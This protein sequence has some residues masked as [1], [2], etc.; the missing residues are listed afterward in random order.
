MTHRLTED[1][2]TTPIPKV[3]CKIEM[4]NL[5]FNINDGSQLTESSWAT[6]D[7][8]GEFSIELL[9]TS[10]VNPAGSHYVLSTPYRPHSDELLFTVPDAGPAKITDFLAED[11]DAP[12][13]VKV[14]LSTD[15]VE[16]LLSSLGLT[17]HRLE[18]HQ[19][20]PASQWTITHT[21]GVKPNVML[22]LPD[23]EIFDADIVLP[24][25]A[26]VIVV[27]ANP[28]TGTAVLT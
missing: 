12:S 3:E 15:E 11:L 7:D 9:P 28:Q 4:P 21:F 22:L 5:A 26:T 27:H 20:T 14:G 6:T 17:S 13:P 18:F 25:N 16:L 1:D 23:G 24:D 10:Q 19:N 2:G 8:N